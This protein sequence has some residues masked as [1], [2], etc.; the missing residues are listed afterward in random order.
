MDPATRRRALVGRLSERSFL[1]RA[2]D[3]AAH[4]RPGVVLLHGEAGVGKTRLLTEVCAAADGSRRVL[5]GRCLRFGATSSPYLPLVTAFDSWLADQS[6]DVHGEL[7]DQVPALT[8]LFPSSGT[9]STGADSRAP[10]EV[11]HGSGAMP[12]AS[13]ADGLVTGW[14]RALLVLCGPEPVVLVVDDVQWADASSL[15][16]LA[17]LVT[18]LR[19]QRLCLLISYRDGELPDGHPLHGWLADLRRLPVTEDLALAPLT[20]DDTREQLRVLLDR[21]PD[22]GLAHAV[23]NRS[24][25]NPYLTELL[26]RGI[27]ADAST[28]PDGL[29]DALRDAVLASWHRLSPAARTLTQILAVA[30]RPSTT[31]RLAAV[32][33]LWTGDGSDVQARTREATGAGVVTVEPTGQVWFRHP[34]LAEVLYP[35]LLPEERSVVHAAFADTA[36]TADLAGGAKA[37]DVD[38]RHS[39]ETARL[40]DRAVHCERAGRLDEAFEYSLAAAQ[41]AKA[42]PAV[43][44]EAVLLGRAVA[45]WPRVSPDVRARHGSEVDLLARAAEAS[46]WAGD[47]AFASR[48]LDRA[49]ALVDPVEDPLTAAR[50]LTFAAES[51]Y[52]SRPEA[53]W[54]VD[55]F[56][57]AVRL[58][59]A[60]PDT[61]EHARALADLAQGEAWA[62]HLAEAR[63]HADRAL[64]AAHRAEDAAHISWA[65]FARCLAYF[66]EPAALDAAAAAGRYA[67]ASG[68]PEFIALAHLAASNAF[69][70]QG[71]L[72]DCATTLLEG[73]AAA[74]QVG[75]GGMTSYLGVYAAQ[76]LLAVGDTDRAEQLLREVL[77]TRPIGLPGVQAQI[78]AMVAAVRHGD[79]A[80]ASRHLHRARELT[81]GFEEQPSLH[82]PTALAEYLLAVGRPGETLTMLRETIG[83]H[84]ATEPRF[85]DQMLAWGARA[86]A[87]QAA[88]M[89]GETGSDRT[90]AERARRALEDL[91]DE[92]AKAGVPPFAYLDDDPT[93]RATQA[94]YDAEVARLSAAADAAEQWRAAVEAAATAGL[95]YTE[96]EALVRLADTLAQQGHRHQAATPMRAAYRRAHDLNA[97]AVAREVEALA[98]LARIDLTDPAPVTRPHLTDSVLAGLTRREREILAHLVAGRSYA[99]IADELFIS[100]KTVGVHVSNLLRKTGTANRVAVAAW[101]RRHGLDVAEDPGSS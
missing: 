9:R 20:E 31:A 13:R 85:A 39:S 101:A 3:D 51:A 29:P 18:G 36:D 97:P 43:R 68:R 72:A 27:D 34:L 73:Y 46:R 78:W 7:A 81:P 99:E 47:E 65:Q 54:P 14:E 2:L 5:W 45:L 16:V 19:R 62:G 57:H 44:E 56:A 64:A 15:D 91:C 24:R 40:A 82:G 1:Q 26:V 21:D 83:T 6:D 71:R 12:A 76:N 79:L 86:A 66:G 60:F 30:G 90:A 50:V 42:M 87:D 93:Q 38:G 96:L 89:S 98:R 75:V 22:P 28:L 41:H 77:A 10:A 84:A 4:G 58:T 23:W 48:L 74:R 94:L 92:R 17:Y 32:A 95:R 25:G 63:V 59:A 11:P 88:Q 37:V 49:R 67:A 80:R 33:R 35:T 53:G 70:S 69:E 8:P 55:Q 100:Q 61:A 52:S